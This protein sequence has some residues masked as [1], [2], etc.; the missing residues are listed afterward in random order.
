MCMS[1]IVKTWPSTVTG[2]MHRKFCEGHVVSEIHEQTVIQTCWFQ[3]TTNL[4]RRAKQWQCIKKLQQVQNN[5]AWIVLD[6]RGTKTIPHSLL[7]R[8]LHWLPVQQRIEYK[9]ALLT[10]KVCSILTPSYLH[11]LIQDRQ[12]SHIQRSATTLSTNHDDNFRKVRLSI[13]HSGCLEL[14]TIKPKLSLTVTRLLFLGF[15][16]WAFSLASSQ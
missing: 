10:F 9:V 2:N 7:L 14:T 8:R 5:A 6:S 11:H 12:H 3:F 4:S 13:L 16:S 1:L 15:F